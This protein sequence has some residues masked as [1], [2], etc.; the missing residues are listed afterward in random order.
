MVKKKDWVYVYGKSGSGKTT[1]FNLLSGQLK[2][3]SGEI[4]FDN[5][6]IN[7]N[8][9]KKFNIMGYIHQNIII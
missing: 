9:Q 1:F 7:K 3:Y 5:E 6:S 8:F 2:P 4:T